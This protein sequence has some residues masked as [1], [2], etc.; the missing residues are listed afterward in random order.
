MR[1]NIAANLIDGIKTCETW[2]PVIKVNAQPPNSPNSIIC[3]LV[4]YIRPNIS[5]F[6]PDPIFPNNAS[7]RFVDFQG[8][9][10]GTVLVKYLSDKA[11]EGDTNLTVS[12]SSNNEYKHLPHHQKDVRYVIAP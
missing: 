2:K 4:K 8:L 12:H 6:V 3:D 7:L 11:K 5:L 10:Q 9:D 1:F